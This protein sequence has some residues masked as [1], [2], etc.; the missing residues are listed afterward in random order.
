MTQSP[1]LRHITDLH[2]AKVDVW[3]PVTIKGLENCCCVVPAR[4]SKSIPSLRQRLKLA[5][6]VFTGRYD[7]LSWEDQP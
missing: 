4:Y 7:A 1:E 3:T 5:W 2:P 6:G